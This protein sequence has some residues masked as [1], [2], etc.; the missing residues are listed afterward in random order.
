MKNVVILA[1]A[2]CLLW[3]GAAIIRL[4]RYHYAAML[5]M[6]RDKALPHQRD[7]CLELT[8]TRTHS[9]FHLL[10]GLRLL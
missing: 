7:E 1:L 6:C 9:I 10:Y 8:E 3:F 4:E 2:A 5:D